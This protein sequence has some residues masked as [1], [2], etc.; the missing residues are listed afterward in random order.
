MA[1]PLGS[2]RIVAVAGLIVLTSCT[3]T[4]QPDIPP[5]PKVTPPAPTLPH[6]HVPA[7]TF[8]RG[9]G[10]AV[11]GALG[12]LTKWSK[13]SI[14]VGSF[15]LVWIRQAARV[16]ASRFREPQAV[17]ILA[18]VKA[19]HPT[20][21]TVPEQER[22]HVSLLYDPNATVGNRYRVQD[23]EESVEFEPCPGGAS[24]AAATQF[25]GG[26]IV[27]G[28]RCVTLTVT[29]AN[30]SRRIRSAFGKRTCA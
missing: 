8:V 10:S 26:V 13:S 3:P 12:P 4:V 2:W 14:I 5:H 25:N 30:E 24:W 27:A 7:G 28:G 15:A 16:P 1:H 18:L 20:L 21:V 29:Q 11:D 23:G 17:K 22:R 19:G 6:I 9:C